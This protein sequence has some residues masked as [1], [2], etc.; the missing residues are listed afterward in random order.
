MATPIT[1]ERV[2]FGFFEADLRSGEL[3]KQGV[4]IKLHH[5]PFQV[6]TML[7]EHP[8]EVVTR[9][10]LKSK[11]WPLDT[12]V[13]FDV[14]LNSA[15]KKLRDALGDSAET[16]RYVETLPRRG[17]RF[18]APLSNGSTSKAE[19][20][21]EVPKPAIEKESSAA[22]EG[23]VAGV[24][25]LSWAH[26]RRMIWASAAVLLGLL[27][28]LVG[29]N[30]G[31]WRKRF[32]ARATPVRIRS[33]AVLPL[34]NLS[35]DPAQEYFVDGM[36]DAVI[37]D[38]AQISSL[39]V[40]S[41]TSVMRYKGTRKPLPEIGKELNVDGIVEGAVVR[42]GERV[43]VDA[44]LIEANTDRHVWARTYERNLGDVIALQN[45][46][47]RAVA[48]EVQV[49]LTPQEQAHLSRADSI[50]PQT[51]ELYL[52]GRYFWS[53]RGEDSIRKS[54]D[55]FQQAIQRSPNY[56]LAHAGLAEAYVVKYDV[57]PQEQYSAAK[58]AARR[59]LEID[60]NL[61]EAHNA[62]AASLFWYDWDWAGAEKEFQRALA[63]NANYA[64]AHQW[65]AQYLRTMGR[66]D[67][68]VEELK[69]A[70]ELE[71]LSHFA[72]GSGRYGQ[73]YDLIIE[74]ARKELELDPSFFR[75]YSALGSAYGL[76]GMY[77][78]S[79][80][81]YQ[82]ARDLSGGSPGV[83]S[84][85]GYTYAVWGKR[86]EAVKILEELKELSKHKYVS[87]YHI[88]K[89]YV[90]LGEKDLAFAW[91]QKAVADR[92][93]PLPGLKTYEELASLRSDP[94]Y[95]ELLNRIGLPQ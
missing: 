54:I 49:K 50:D 39:K 14:G 52:R 23:T 13:D 46:I 80:A 32:L 11:L 53:K 56:A 12:F 62:L 5:Q 21:L 93:I 79:I 78:D 72:G 94:R 9:E 16:P 82:K 57:A 25:A 4:R 41:R 30:A 38:L 42:S 95:T 22:S 45:E 83:L 66:R 92:S 7:L 81:A 20:A 51:Y 43:R 24:P 91:L 33:I 37:T 89:V 18:I 73:Q 48:N 86:A 8:G 44:Q 55:Y 84:G 67:S 40:V 63:L 88:A 29:L 75:A 15:V 35:S 58:P 59:A 31:G 34:E 74:H 69:R 26:S 65:Y 76:K 87:P 10:E 1:S 60:N 28:L 6:L 68:A 77:R 47:A 2:R 85:M 19:S 27:V 3:R 36:T 71:P 90:G 70:E 61:A 64:Q 17:Y